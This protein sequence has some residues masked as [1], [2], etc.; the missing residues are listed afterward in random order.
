MV[1]KKNLILS[2]HVD[3]ELLGCFSY[4]NEETHVME[5][6]ADEF[7]VV[8]REER[9]RELE[10]LANHCNFTYK[11]FDNIVNNY[12]LQDL[13]EQITRRSL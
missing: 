8:D 9:V 4:L 6:G 10:D 12:V 5:C 7:H 13:I 2:P 1:E 11:V 3:D